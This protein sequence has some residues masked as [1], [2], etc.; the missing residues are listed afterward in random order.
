MTTSLLKG[1]NVYRVL[2]GSNGKYYAHVDNSSCTPDQELLL[3]SDN[4]G[5]TWTEH[6]I[7][8]DKLGFEFPKRDYP[9]AWDVAANNDIYVIVNTDNGNSDIAGLYRSQDNGDTWTRVLIP[10]DIPT[11]SSEGGFV[12]VRAGLGNDV[13]VVESWAF[14]GFDGSHFVSGTSIKLHLYD[15]TNWSLVRNVVLFTDSNNWGYD[16]AILHGI[17]GVNYVGTR[18]SNFST[19]KRVWR[20]ENFDVEETL[21]PDARELY[22]LAI[23][24]ANNIALYGLSNFPF[25]TQVYENDTLVRTF[26]RLEEDDPTPITYGDDYYSLST[27]TVLY[28]G[29]TTELAANIPQNHISI[30]SRIAAEVTGRFFINVTLVGAT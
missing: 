20:V 28:K 13:W 12:S 14:S 11:L 7:S 30:S 9:C 10:D 3:V 15:K 25:V 18:G 17:N 29:L 5:L 22:D 8:F 26:D 4:Q 23:K 6:D 21:Y 24:D 27:S 16:G 2:I 1:K 19:T